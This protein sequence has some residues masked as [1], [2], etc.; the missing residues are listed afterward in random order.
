MASTKAKRMTAGARKSGSSMGVKGRA[1][2]GSATRAEVAHGMSV[3]SG[4]G[5]GTRRSASSGRRR[6]NEGRGERDMDVLLSPA[7]IVSGR[8]ALCV[9]A[10][11]KL[12]SLC[13]VLRYEVVRSIN[14]RPCTHSLRLWTASAKSAR[15][16]KERLFRLGGARRATR[17]VPVGITKIRPAFT[18]GP[19]QR[20]RESPTRVLK[21][22]TR[23]DPLPA[24]AASIISYFSTSHSTTIHSHH[25]R[26]SRS[27][28]SQ[29]RESTR[30]FL[31]SA[32][33]SRLQA[34]SLLDDR[35]V[36]SNRPLIP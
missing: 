11:D 30:P 1:R 25:V 14:R 2:V 7:A 33:S 10:D 4:R 5:G 28:I 16:R 6:M 26:P 13:R 12:S 23:Y 3:R 8:C 20:Q 15:E 35:R 32:S 18:M 22:L 29:R 34:M 24:G 19:P 31:S 36:K 9:L 21:S 17:R 27:T